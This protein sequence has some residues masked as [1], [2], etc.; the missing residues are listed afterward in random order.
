MSCSAHP[1]HS[2]LD[3]GSN[4]S[5][6]QES[7]GR[8]QARDHIL[9][10]GALWSHAVGWR[11]LA[12]GTVRL[13]HYKLVSLNFAYLYTPLSESSESA[14]ISTARIRLRGWPA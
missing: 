13:I 5:D 10:F 8:T 4:S 12:D 7:S 6:L 9:L 11:H 1:W 2:G 14:N 3:I